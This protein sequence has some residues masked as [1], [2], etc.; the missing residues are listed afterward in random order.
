MTSHDEFPRVLSASREMAAG[1]GKIFELIADPARQP[2]WDGNKNLAEAPVGQ[3]IRREGE[4][5][6]MTLTSGSVRETHVV[7]FEEGRRIA[8]KPAEVALST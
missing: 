4:V 1:A 6:M 5:F 3:R 7:E 2:R 8:W